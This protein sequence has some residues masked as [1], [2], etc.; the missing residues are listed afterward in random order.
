M[1]R[2]RP[3]YKHRTC[4]QLWVP[5]P[6][7]WRENSHSDLSLLFSARE[8]WRRDQ[9]WPRTDWVLA[10]LIQTKCRQSTESGQEFSIILKS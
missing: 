10:N 7:R 5:R 9:D 4:L 3:N 1:I 6:E 2:W 8:N